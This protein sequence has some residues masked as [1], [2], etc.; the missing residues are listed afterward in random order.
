MQDGTPLSP[1]SRDLANYEEYA[2]RELPRLVRASVLE[3]FSR[4]MQPVEASLIANLVDTIQD[5]QARLFRS[6][7]EWINEDE[8]ADI[9]SVSM[10]DAPISPPSPSPRDPPLGLQY[11]SVE[12][13]SMH[14]PSNLLNA[15]FQQ[16]P[17]LRD[18]VFEPNFQSH[19]PMHEPMH[20]PQAFS[21]IGA[22][23]SSLSE[24]VFSSHGYGSE[25]TAATDSSPS[26]AADS[27]CPQGG[28]NIQDDTFKWQDWNNE[29]WDEWFSAD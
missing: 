27:T 7:W 25:H 26:K 4:E 19:E 11:P 14:T 15:A 20:D 6:Y 28:P 5:C 3:V 8:Q 10:T 17:P 2:R 13:M 22:S 29:P 24:T 21:T 23:L 18:T 9:P 12:R 1:D 16:P